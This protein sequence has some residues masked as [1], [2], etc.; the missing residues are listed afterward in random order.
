VVGEAAVA[1]LCSRCSGG[2]AWLGLRV[3]GDV[4]VRGRR[5]AP[6]R[7]SQRLRTQEMGESRCGSATRVQT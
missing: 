6:S 5:K 3:G 2:D 1:G 7:R 4:L